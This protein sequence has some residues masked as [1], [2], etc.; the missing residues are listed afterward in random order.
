MKPRSPVSYGGSSWMCPRL[1]RDIRIRVPIGYAE[2]VAVI[3]VVL[4][5]LLLRTVNLSGL[6]AGFHG[7]EAVIRQL[8]RNDARLSHMLQAS[9]V[10]GGLTGEIGQTVRTISSAIGDAQTEL[11]ILSRDARTAPNT[12]ARA[13]SHA[14]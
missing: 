7:D 9:L 11:S 3:A 6:P 8:Q 10:D 2:L 5:A 13:I 14:A 12:E 1:S 4:L